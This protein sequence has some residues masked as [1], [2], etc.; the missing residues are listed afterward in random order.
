MTEQMRKSPSNFWQ[1][2]G[3]FMRGLVRLVLFGLVV[4]IIVV[5]IYFAAPFA[6]P[7]ISDFTVLPTKNKQALDDHLQRAHP[8]PQMQEDLAGQLADQRERIAQ[9]ETDLAAERE[10]RSE[11]QSQLGQQAETIAAQI[12]A[13]AELETDLD[14]QAQDTTVQTDLETRLEAQAQTL[15][16]LKQSVDTLD[17][18]VT[19]LDA[20]LTRVEQGITKPELGSE[21]SE[22]QQQILILQVSQ[23]ILKARLHLSENNSGQA[24]LALEQTGLA[25]AQLESLNLSEK[26]ED[27]AEIQA[28]LETVMT[29]IEEQPFIVSQELEILW[30]LLQRFTE[31]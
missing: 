16:S 26:E 8:H 24:Q 9:L 19:D 28:Q 5:A 14:T 20:A 12:T 18:S 23:A 4:A 25:L 6:A 15:T 3:R 29:A 2:F 22:L 1:S 31:S 7:Y 10:A 21:T 30:Q 27:L 11:L 17:T 13:Q